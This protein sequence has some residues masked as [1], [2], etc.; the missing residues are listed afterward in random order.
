MFAFL[1]QL[2]KPGPFDATKGNVARAWDLFAE[3]ESESVLAAHAAGSGEGKRSAIRALTLVEG[4]LPKAQIAEVLPMLGDPGKSVLAVARFNVATAGKGRIS[5]VGVTHAWLDG[6]PLAVASDPRPV[7]DLT[8][9]THFLTVKIETERLPEV[10]RVSC[11]EVRFL[12]D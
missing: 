4:T 11:D 10:L 7:L 5:L 9:G 1:S 2:G 8:P 3:R 12:N 6:R